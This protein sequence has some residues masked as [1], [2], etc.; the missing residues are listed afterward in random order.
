ML[1]RHLT[2]VAMLVAAS[3]GWATVR[4]CRKMTFEGVGF[5]DGGGYTAL[6]LAVV[7]IHLGAVGVAL[8]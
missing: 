5:E 6:L 7:M 4:I 1:V 3:S 8:S 2:L